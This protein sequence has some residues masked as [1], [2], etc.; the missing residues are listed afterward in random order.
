MN[1]SEVRAVLDRQVT[2]LR[3]VLPED[4]HWRLVLLLAAAEVIGERKHDDEPPTRL[5]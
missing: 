3:N 5:H 1:T 4:V 2:A